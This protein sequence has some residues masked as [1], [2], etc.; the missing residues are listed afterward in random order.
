M[1]ALHS[2]FPACPNCHNAEPAG[3]IVDMKRLPVLAWVKSKVFLDLSGMTPLTAMIN[4]PVYPCPA[5]HLHSGQLQAR[6][7][8][9]RVH[10]A[11]K[12]PIC[13]DLRLA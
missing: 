2:V 9:T 3:Q 10:R 7:G 4:D 6:P 12:V 8:H 1:H 13:G 5:F 11:R